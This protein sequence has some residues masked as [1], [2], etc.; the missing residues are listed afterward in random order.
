MEKNNKPTK[1][2]LS[3]KVGNQE[4]VKAEEIAKDIAE[5][6]VQPQPTNGSKK[7]WIYVAVILGALVV[8]SIAV[9]QC[10]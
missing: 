3:Q 6:K 7:V 4:S 5:Q 1:D 10:S 2:E 8:A 9:H